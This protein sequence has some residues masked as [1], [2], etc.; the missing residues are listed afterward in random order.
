[1]QQ[2]LN[3]PELLEEFDKAYELAAPYR[4]KVQ[5]KLRLLQACKI[6]M[7]KILLL[8][9]VMVNCFVD[10]VYIHPDLKA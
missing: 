1:M 10:P 3:D 6:F 8:D 2:I 7:G 4:A 9:E 5:Y